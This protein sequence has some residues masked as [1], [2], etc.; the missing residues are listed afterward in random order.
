MP[1]QPV[2]KPKEIISILEKS[3]FNIRRTTGSHYVLKNTKRKKI[4]I[5]PFHTKDLP[6]GTLKSIFEMAG[7]DWKNLEKK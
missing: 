3:G 7:I 5:V 1:K 6:P 4:V 2:L